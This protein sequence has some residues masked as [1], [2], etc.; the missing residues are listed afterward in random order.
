MRTCKSPINAQM[1]FKGSTLVQSQT[2]LHKG[3]LVLPY[4]ASAWCRVA[5]TFSALKRNFSL[6]HLP[7]AFALRSIENESRLLVDP[8]YLSFYGS[9]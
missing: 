4:H 3:R 9:K 1:V 2:S 8:S 6:D 5:L 7:V